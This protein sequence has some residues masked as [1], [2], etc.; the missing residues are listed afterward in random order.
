M[1]DNSQ[2]LGRK[3]PHKIYP[4]NLHGFDTAEADPFSAPFID[5]EDI[6]TYSAII[7]CVA[8]TQSARI[9]IC[10]PVDILHLCKCM[11]DVV[12]T[13]ARLYAHWRVFICKVAD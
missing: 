2:I 9:Q 11:P 4:R 7:Q 6:L 5:F 12:I 13:E 1:A 3:A 10:N 8:P